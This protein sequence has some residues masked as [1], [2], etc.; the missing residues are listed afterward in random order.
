MFCTCSVNVAWPSPPLPQRASGVYIWPSKWTSMSFSA[1]FACESVVHLMF[2]CNFW[3]TYK[4]IW[5]FCSPCLVRKKYSVIKVNGFHDT[6]WLFH[7]TLGLK[8]SSSLASSRVCSSYHKNQ[9]IFVPPLAAICSV[10]AQRAG[11]FELTDCGQ[12]WK[13]APLPLMWSVPLPRDLFRCSIVAN[14]VWT[15][16]Q[17]E[18]VTGVNLVILIKS[19]WDKLNKH[20]SYMHPVVF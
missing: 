19:A 3:N 6:C 15:T 7:S 8:S 9:L 13:P 18:C 5:H 14:T 4:M 17:H 10:L 12:S 1:A 20:T 2:V 11:C 16:F